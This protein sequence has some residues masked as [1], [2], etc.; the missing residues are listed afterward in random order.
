M[1]DENVTEPDRGKLFEDDGRKARNTDRVGAVTPDTD[2]PEPP[3]PRTRVQKARSRARP[4]SRAPR[5]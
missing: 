4:I 5:G 1:T 2:P 3:P